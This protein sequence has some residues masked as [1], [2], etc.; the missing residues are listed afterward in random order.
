M[1]PIKKIGAVK[2]SSHIELVNRFC[3][4]VDVIGKIVPLAMIIQ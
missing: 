3:T 1:E 2:L 4:R